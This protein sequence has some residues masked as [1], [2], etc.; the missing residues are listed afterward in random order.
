MV[1]E[2]LVKASNGEAYTPV[3]KDGTYEAK[4]TEPSFGW[5]AEV[6]VVVVDGQ[7]V[8]L[9]YKELAIEASD[10][11]QVGDRKTADNYPYARPVEIAKEL[12]KLIIDNNGTD[13]L[14]VDGIS[15]AT[16]TRGGMI[17]LVN[18]AL[19]SAK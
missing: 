7:I 10:G 1:G 18:Q 5:L 12:Q 13:N 17:D 15:G 8:G 2:V 11:V 9:D 6:T 4:A 3:L 14:D 19:S 16:E